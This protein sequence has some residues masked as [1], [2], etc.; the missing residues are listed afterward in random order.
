MP[1]RGVKYSFKQPCSSILHS[2]CSSMHGQ[3]TNLSFLTPTLRTRGCGS[4]W[5]SL[6]F[7]L[8]SLVT[9]TVKNLPAV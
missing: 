1:G 8:A 2:I 3:P 6:T 7:T 9:Q 4:T 5:D